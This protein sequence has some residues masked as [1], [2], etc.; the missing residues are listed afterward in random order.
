MSPAERQYQRIAADLRR[1][2][3]R[4]EWQTGD[5]L[6]S[7]AKLAIEYDVDANVLQ[8]AQQ[9]LITEGLLE[10]RTGSGTYV[11]RPVPRREM[12]RSRIGTP[13]SFRADLG[14]IDGSG[15]WESTTNTN[16]PAP[17]EVAAR[18]GIEPGA[19]TVHTVYE[20]LIDS[21]P[22]LL[23]NSWEPLALTA[24]SPVICPEYG[25]LAGQGV[26]R[27]MAEIG[28]RVERAVERTRPSRATGTQ[29]NLL[30]V[31][32]GDLVTLIERT[33]Y[34]REGRAVETADLVV[35]DSRWDISY[36]LPIGRQES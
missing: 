4:G 31:S 27:R 13:A 20:F 1:R 19:P 16:S 24:G 17:P 2:I 22:V 26:V 36:E 21:Q 23:A 28:V 32:A 9:L 11:R 35:P 33:Y 25:P 30:G 3:G 5:C 12:V 10:G 14:A 29:A 18:L 6:P 34:D 15:S 7:R 8:R